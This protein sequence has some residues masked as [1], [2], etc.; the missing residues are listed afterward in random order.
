M[1][2]LPA[3]PLVP[4]FGPLP[5]GWGWIAVLSLALAWVLCLPG[6]LTPTQVLTGGAPDLPGLAYATAE[7]THNGPIRWGHSRMLM[8]PGISNLYAQMSFPADTFSAA[9]LV[10][11][12]GWPAGFTAHTVLVL[13]AC[14]L[15]T[16]LVAASWWR[17]LGA[18]LVA[19]GAMETSGIVLREAAEGR[20]TH[21]NGLVLAAPAVWAFSRAL[22]EDRGR[23]AFL[24]GILLGASGLIF[25]YQMV[26][27]VI[28][29]ALLGVAALVE[30][31]PLFRHVAWG[32]LGTFAVAGFPLLYTLLHAGAHPGS[33]ASAF[34]VIEES[35]GNPI[36]LIFLLELRSVD[37]YGWVTGAWRVRPL[38]VVLALFAC[39]G[40]RPRRWLL[41]VVAIGVAWLLAS[42]PLWRLPGG[43]YFSPVALQSWVPVMRR[44]WWPDRYLLIAAPMVSILV[45]GGA[46]IAVVRLR[47]LG[48]W[49]PR[50]IARILGL[51]RRGEGLS[52][53]VPIALIALCCVGLLLEARLG[54]PTLPMPTTPGT[55]SALTRAMAA[56]AG[57]TLVLPPRD[58]DPLAENRVWHSSVFIQTVHHGRPLLTGLMNP[59][60]IVADTTYAAFWNDAFLRA[61][62]G[63]EKGESGR[64]T[65]EA[66]ALGKA[67]IYRAGVRQIYADP[68]LEGPPSVAAAWRSC[69]EGLLGDPVETGEGYRVYGLSEP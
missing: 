66:V 4:R 56:G 24:T 42:G 31:L 51:D 3:A 26:W 54:Y 33:E 10:A 36:Y 2:S 7:M 69:I 13:A 12:F 27:C 14:G 64:D 32:A 18:G 19:A 35:P 50:R 6:S 8:F 63:C 68:S 67:R 55:A 39:I 30:R 44:Y 47:A 53:R 9:P 65:A 16:G 37:M 52:P 59:D 58:L 43:V 61:L 38:L 28:P 5:R 41:P 60:S 21:D 15:S 62:R 23:Y 48:R 57:P 29:L 22:V 11:L 40:T 45:G 34:S 1:V 20:L 25:W 17:S 49:A 46:V